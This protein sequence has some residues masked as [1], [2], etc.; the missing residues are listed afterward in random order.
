MTYIRSFLFTYFTVLFKILLV[1]GLFLT[2]TAYVI[3][4]FELN[5]YYGLP[6]LPI[7]EMFL[8]T[9]AY[10]GT[11]LIGAWLYSPVDSSKD[12]STVTVEL[13]EKTPE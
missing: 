1:G 10:A 4:T 13:E 12:E 5:N 2:T 3:N 9:V 8:V 11:F 6:N 7:Q